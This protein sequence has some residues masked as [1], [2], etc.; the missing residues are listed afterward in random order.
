MKSAHTDTGRMIAPDAQ[1]HASTASARSGRA[2]TP[3]GA[4]NATQG[5]ETASRA[6]RRKRLTTKE[7][8]QAAQAIEAAGTLL[9]NAIDAMDAARRLPAAEREA[10]QKRQWR[11]IGLVLDDHANAMLVFL[12]FCGSHVGRTE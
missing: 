4:G 1:K 9:V 5:A 2:S 12:T 11:E 6:K 3:A 7:A 10:E 8:K